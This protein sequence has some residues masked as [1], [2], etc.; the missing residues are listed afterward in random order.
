MTAGDELRVLIAAVIDQRFVYAAITGA[1][2][3]GHILE[4]ESLDYIHHEVGTG[5][6]E[7]WQVRRRWVG[8]PSRGGRAGV[9]AGGRR[10]LLGAQL[11]RCTRNQSCHATDGG[12]FQKVAAINAVL[13]W[14][15]HELNT[16]SGMALAPARIL[17]AEHN[18]TPSVRRNKPITSKKF[19]QYR[20]SARTNLRLKTRCFD[21]R[22][23]VLWPPSRPIPV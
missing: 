4:A 22:S 11:H 17:W 10:R 18:T 3:G 1:G 5:A 23:G 9:L 21:G 16:S 15:G 14:L 19:Q 2:I 13:L 7:S 20:P 6:L 8:S 12:S